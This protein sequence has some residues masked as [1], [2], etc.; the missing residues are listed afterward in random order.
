MNDLIGIL[1]SMAIMAVAFYPSI[2]IHEI[3]HYIAARLL[4]VPVEEFGLLPPKYSDAYGKTRWSFHGR[5][6][7]STDIYQRS[8]ATIRTIAAAGPLASLLVGIIFAYFHVW[9]ISLLNITI[10]GIAILGSDGKRI[11]SPYYDKDQKPS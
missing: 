8:G 4:N 2:F 9:T 5:V 7:I 6:T 10:C 1:T 11:L 3:G